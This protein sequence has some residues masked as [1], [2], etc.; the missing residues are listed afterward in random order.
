MSQSR[1]Q[2]HI[3]KD[4]TFHDQKKQKIDDTSSKQLFFSSVKNGIT[5]VELLIV[6]IIIGFSLASII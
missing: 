3:D 2:E 6:I 4:Y 1:I 5:L